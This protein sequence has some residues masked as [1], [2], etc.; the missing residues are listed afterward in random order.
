MTPHAVAENCEIQ[1]TFPVSQGAGK[2]Y[3]RNGGFG[4]Y[5]SVGKASF[6]VPSTRRESNTGQLGLYGRNEFL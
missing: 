1:Y 6:F 2:R 5:V 4:E 3:W